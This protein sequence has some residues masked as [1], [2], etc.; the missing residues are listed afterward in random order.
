MVP[1]N[2]VV[3]IAYG[4]GSAIK[5]GLIDNVKTIL[6][7]RKVF[8]YGGIEP[9]PKYETLMKAVEIVRSENID[10]IL[11][12]TELSC[13]EQALKMSS[14]R[15]TKAEDLLGYPNR[16]TMRRRINRLREVYPELFKEY[17]LVNLLYSEI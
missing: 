16:Q 4:G 8:E 14:G 11:A 15:K 1:A 2:A 6:G 10:Y 12:K 5:S 9:N 13:V 17:D 3:L 7:D